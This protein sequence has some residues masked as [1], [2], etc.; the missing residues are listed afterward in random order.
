MVRRMCFRIRT[1]HVKSL[2]Y[3]ELANVA[4]AAVENLEASLVWMMELEYW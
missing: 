2:H 4:M 3:Q 1:P